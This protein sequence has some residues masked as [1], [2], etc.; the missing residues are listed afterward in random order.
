MKRRLHEKDNIIKDEK[1]IVK[2]LQE[3]LV[4]SQN[5]TDLTKQK[6]KKTE[7]DLNG[8]IDQKDEKIQELCDELLQKDTLIDKQAVLNKDMQKKVDATTA[9]LTQTV[10]NL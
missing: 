6:L 1:A 3:Q 8:V 2:Q 7:K 4:E 9:E 10:Q 5:E